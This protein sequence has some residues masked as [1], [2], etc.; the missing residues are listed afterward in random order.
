MNSKRFFVMALF[1]GLFSL[2]AVQGQGPGGGRPGGPGGPPPPRGSEEFARLLNLTEAQKAQ[3]RTIREQAAAAAKP[4]HEQ[5]E[6]L[7][8]QTEKLTHAATFDEAAVRAL[9]AKVAQLETELHVI[10]S[11]AEN[12]TFNLLTPEQKAKLEE[13]HKMMQAREPGRPGGRPDR[14]PK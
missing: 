13:L 5:L 9:A 11:R 2:G 1:S 6:P 12:A 8:E 10:H 7:H 3:S 4:Y 14:L